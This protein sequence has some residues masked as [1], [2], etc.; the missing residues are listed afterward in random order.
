MFYSLKW[1]FELCMVV[2]NFKNG[3][4]EV[5]ITDSVFFI[6]KIKKKNM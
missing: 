5:E 1:K 3:I 2:I 6:K 4:I